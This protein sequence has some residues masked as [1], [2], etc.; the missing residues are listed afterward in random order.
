MTRL[1][2]MIVV[3]VALAVGLGV[4]SWA[5]YLAAGWLAVG[6]AA[7]GAV[8]VALIFLGRRIRPGFA[9]M[10]LGAVLLAV[11]VGNTNTSAGVFR[12]DD[13]AH[14]WRLSS[15]TRRTARPPSRPIRSC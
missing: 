3:L 7:L 10:A 1:V 2:G 13:L 12:G 5:F 11:N 6:F 8:L 9:A 4:A 14:H 15:S